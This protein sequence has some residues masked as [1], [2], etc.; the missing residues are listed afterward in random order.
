MSYLYIPFVNLSKFN[1]LTGEIPSSIGNLINLTSLQ[2]SWHEGIIGE[3][4]SEMGN[5]VHLTELG[6]N[7]NNLT[8]EI[9]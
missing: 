3:I 4:P 8:G 1:D 2:L 6:L 5:L 7:E 9:P